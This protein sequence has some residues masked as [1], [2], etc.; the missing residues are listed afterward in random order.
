MCSYPFPDMLGV[1]PQDVARRLRGQRLV[2]LVA[3]PGPVL[4]KRQ[5]LGWQ[6]QSRAAQHW[7]TNG[8]RAEPLPPNRL[9]TAGLSGLRTGGVAFD[10]E[11][12]LLRHGS[13]GQ[14]KGG[15]GRVSDGNQNSPRFRLTWTPNPPTHTTRRLRPTDEED[16]GWLRLN[17]CRFF[18]FST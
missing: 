4:V 14:G 10:A 11:W 12:L 2:A 1:R 17:V 3:I 8:R 16:P 9:Q 5:P 18:F 13:T 6:V 15:A 7:K